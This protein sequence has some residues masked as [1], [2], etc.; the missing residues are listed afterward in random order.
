M[1]IIFNNT[2]P[3]KGFKAI[4]LWPWVFVRNE[5]KSRFTAIDSNHEY[6]HL[7]QQKEM[8]VT[9]F[10]LALI[11]IICRLSW[12]YSLL[13]VPIFFI[14]YGVEWFLRWIWYGFSQN[15]AYRNVC[16]EQEA[17]SN[18]NNLDY[19]RTRKHFSFVRYLFKK[20]YKAR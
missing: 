10:I 1:K 5:C 15:E 17:Y 12:Y 18:E 3:F 8:A 16:F 4:A 20:S 2:I 19:L 6:I 7:R 11:A 9:G 14:W 13:F